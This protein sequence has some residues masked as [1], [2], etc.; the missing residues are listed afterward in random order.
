MRPGQTLTIGKEYEELTDADLI[1]AAS[2]AM[3][4][5]I[6]QLLVCNL[7]LFSDR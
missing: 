3:I 7:R 4:I 2:E 1:R 6:S 5:R